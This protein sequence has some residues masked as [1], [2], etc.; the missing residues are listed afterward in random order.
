[1]S[2]ADR[3]IS[4]FERN[5]SLLE[6][7]C[8]VIKGF[9]ANTEKATVQVYKEEIEKLWSE[10][11]ISFEK[12]EALLTGKKDDDLKEYLADFGAMHN[13]FISAR[14]TIM[15]CLN[16]HMSSA[17]D[18][19]NTS[20]HS[21]ETE[22]FK[23]NFKLP[24]IQ[25]RPFNGNLDDWPE[26]KAACNSVFTDRIPQV[27]RLQYLKDLLN[28]EPRNLIKHIAPTDGSYDSAWLILKTKYDNTRAI[29]NSC[30]K[31]FFDLPSLEAETSSGLNDMLNITNSTMATLKSFQIDVST[32][33][34]ILVYVL[35]RKLDSNSIKHW[36]ETQKGS[37]CVATLMTFLDFLSTRINILSNTELLLPS[38]QKSG[39]FPTS[40][41]KFNK[42]KPQ[43]IMLTLKSNFKCFLCSDNHIIARCPTLMQADSNDRNKMINERSLCRNCFNRHTTESC[44]YTATCKYCDEAHHSLLHEPKKAM[45]ATTIIEPEDECLIEQEQIFHVA[46]GQNAIL[47]T[48]V[49]PV[50][51]NGKTIMIRALIDQGGT[52]S[53]I[54]SKLCQHLNL[55][56]KS[57]YVPLTGACDVKIGCIKK[58]TN[59]TI[60]SNFDPNFSL[61]FT[62]Y[63]VKTVTG[64]K[65]MQV[66]EAKEWSHLKGLHLADPN[67]LE[68]ANIDMLLGNVVFAEILQNGLVKG[69]SG[70]PI[71]QL[72]S[73]GW[74]ITGAA[75]KIKEQEIHCNLMLENDELNQQ[76]A[77]FWQ[78]E[79]VNNKKPLTEDEQKAGDIFVS[80]VKR[81]E[82]GKF[83]VD[84]PFKSDP[85]QAFG[86]S[87]SM[88]RNRL[89]SL[90]RKL[91]K[92]PN[93]EKQY[94]DSLQE[95]LTLGHMS[96]A[97]NDEKP[98]VCLPHHAVIK[99]SSSTTKVRGV[100]DASAKTSNGKSLNDLLY[101][102]P[103]IQPDLFELLIRWRRFQFAFSGDIEKMYRMVKINPIH[104]NFQSILWQPPGETQIQRYKLETATF[105]TAS[106]PFQAIRA[107]HE[108]AN[109]IK[110]LHPIIAANILL[111]FYVD[112]Y[113]GCEKTIEE[114]RAVREEITKILAEFGFNLRKWKASHEEILTGVPEKDRETILDFE[115]SVKTLGIQWNPSKDEFVFNSCEENTP[116]CWT[117][118]N[119]LSEI[120]KLFDPCGW[121]SPC[122]VRAKIIMQNIWRE[123][124][125]ID[126][127][128]PLS[129]ELLAQ[130]LPV[131]QQLCMPIPIKLPRW[132]GMSNEVI[133]A[134]LHGFSDAS[135]AAYA[136]AIYLRLVY[137]SGQVVCNLIAAKTKVAPM[138]PIATIP[139]LELCGAL[140]LARLF[141]KVKPALDYQ[142][143]SIF[144]WTD[145]MITLSWLASHPSKWSVFV[146]NRTSE[147]LKTLPYN[148]W[149]HVPTKENPADLASRGLLVDEL[150]NSSVWWH[151]PEF[152]LRAENKCDKSFDPVNEDELPEHRK[153]IH[154]IQTVENDTLNYFSDYMRL[155][156]FS[157]LALRWLKRSKQKTIAMSSPITAEEISDAEN[158]WIRV[159]QENR[160]SGEIL[161][162]KNKTK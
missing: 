16:A 77:A 31:R 19:A 41:M 54:T 97:S 87:Y 100:F 107:L 58:K 11:Y 17:S 89:R 154:T 106:A 42:P 69:K 83:I 80:S 93:L 116:P 136:A 140:L 37:K 151:G 155:L 1:M 50:T 120:A 71:A 6:A 5:E 15:Q 49:F 18:N 81:G 14:I 75:N 113:L 131:Y 92:D 142:N 119:V 94:N 145:S 36:E 56:L 162:L 135:M 121:C 38:E 78:L 152:L 90:Q 45:I 74:L 12:V 105:G 79:E 24:P 118:R 13:K 157:A 138:N 2:A 132:I 124:E 95:Y 60:G 76:L 160:F 122:V 64:L 25:I 43:P 48:A 26:F 91:A 147:I 66:T 55:P 101:V 82:D 104:A 47:G 30:L 159:V 108:I 46:L 137:A 111:K 114:A 67:F 3:A 139:R 62:A 23:P 86:E 59:V 133:K 44:P 98:F 27:Q 34:A 158:N 129:E 39:Y 33:D 110:H 52:G 148:H 72:T 103:T 130:W 99:E 70:E 51:H 28:G 85:L 63:V 144:A 22:A 7:N 117:K 73:L 150:C 149:Y 143:A 134:E 8:K 21:C 4:T 115:S 61:T 123:N 161:S 156:R 53:L 96:K 127:D 141:E 32:W 57:T 88:A 10:F 35:S 109:R 112:D 128:D 9:D 153:Q 102:G 126:W 125:K 40:N 84:L 65:P 29:V 68:F 20:I 146:A